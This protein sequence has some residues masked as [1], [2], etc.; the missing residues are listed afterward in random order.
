MTKPKHD[1]P[2]PLDGFFR[3]Q[4][5]VAKATARVNREAEN[6]LAEPL[7]KEAWNSINHLS[8]RPAWSIRSRR[9]TLGLLLKMWRG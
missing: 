7:S 1:L 8:W 2:E 4:E 3:G 6:R 5:A 9:G